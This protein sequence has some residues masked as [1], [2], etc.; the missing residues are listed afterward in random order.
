M[1]VLKSTLMDDKLK[2]Q[3]FTHDGTISHLMA[4]CKVTVFPGSQLPGPLFSFSLVWM[5]LLGHVKPRWV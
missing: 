5:T 3:Y 4:F 1:F 2:D